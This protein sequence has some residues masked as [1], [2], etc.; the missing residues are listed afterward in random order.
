MIKLSQQFYNLDNI[1]VCNTEKNLNIK[2]KKKLRSHLISG[3]IWHWTGS[4][5][6]LWFKFLVIINLNWNITGSALRALIASLWLLKIKWVR[7]TSKCPNNIFFFFFFFFFTYFCFP[8]AMISP[9]PA[10]PIC[11]KFQH[12]LKGWD[13]F[14]FHP[15]L[16]LTTFSFIKSSS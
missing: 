14:N 2:G 15:V 11:D 9:D 10:S 4:N 12:W 1:F 7:E 6:Q 5:W 3:Q 16:S 8:L 13:T